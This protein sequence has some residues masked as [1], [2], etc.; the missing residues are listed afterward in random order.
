HIKLIGSRFFDWIAAGK[1]VYTDLS[2]AIGFA[3]RWLA[4]E[5]DR[6]GI[7]GDRVLFASDEPWGDHAGELARLRAAADG[8]ELADAV[9]RT[10]F[11]KLYS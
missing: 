6:R 10:N 3:P 2:W 4:S 8:S 5:I 7:G 1:Q 9:L 11:E